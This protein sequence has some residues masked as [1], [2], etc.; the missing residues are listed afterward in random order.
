MASKAENH[1]HR[2]F[3]LKTGLFAGVATLTI[4]LG[5]IA[6]LVPMFIVGVDDEQA[7][8]VPVYT[9]LEQAGRDIYVREG[10]YNC[11]SQM[12]RPMYAET[13]RYGEWSRSAEYVHDH[14][15]QLGS[16]RIGPDLAREGGVRTDSWHWDHMRDPRQMSPGSIMPTYT[17]LHTATVDVADI[18]ASL[19]ALATVGAPY[20][21]A[22]IE[23]VGTSMQTQGQAIVDRLVAD[24]IEGASWDL[25]IV[26]LIAYLQR[27]GTSIDALTGPAPAA[28]ASL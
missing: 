25:E 9:A 6:E 17:W 12:V 18:Q 4:L 22:D 21:P 14:P 13:M 11:H 1:W 27:L 24:G 8:K 23:S 2:V 10:C 3:E 26:A 16:R 20:S 15:F 28:S 7:A 5:G 19:R